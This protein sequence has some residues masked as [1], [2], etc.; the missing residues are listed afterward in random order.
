[1]NIDDAVRAIESSNEF[2]LLRSLKG[3]SDWGL[4]GTNP[5]ALTG[6]YVDVETTGLS[7]SKDEIVELCLLPFSYDPNTG[8]ILDVD[9]A[10]AID[11]LSDPGIPIPI[12]ATQ[13]HGITNEDVAGKTINS[14]A[15]RRFEPHRVRRR[16]VGLS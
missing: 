16:L 4:K 8:E 9:M 10:N 13:V 15:V 3:P 7:T 14:E 11:E 5:T 2:K 12:E 6:L 1:M